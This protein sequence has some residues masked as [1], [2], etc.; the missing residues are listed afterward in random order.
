[1]VEDWLP[2]REWFAAESAAYYATAERWRRRASDY[3]ERA[4]WENDRE[5]SLLEWARHFDAGAEAYSEMACRYNGWAGTSWQRP[6]RVVLAEAREWL[7][8]E[9]WER[10]EWPGE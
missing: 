7:G 8:A 10:R 3:R 2:P 1:P 5:E 6:R 9:R 4:E